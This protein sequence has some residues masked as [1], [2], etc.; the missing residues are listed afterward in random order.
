MNDAPD[1]HYAKTA[2]GVR[3]AYQ[4]IGEPGTDVIWLSGAQYPI[5]LLWDWPD[6]SRFFMR[7]ASF[8]RVLLLDP[9]GWG[10][11]EV[12]PPTFE[13]FVDDAITVMDA[14]GSQRATLVGFAEGGPVAIL[15]AAIFPE[16]TAGLILLNTFAKWLRS[17][18]YPCGLP[19]RAADIMLAGVEA[20]WG[21]GV[22]AVA[23][24]TMAGDDAFR[25]WIAR[26]ERLGAPPNVAQREIREWMSRDL[27]PILT[28]VRVPTLVLHRAD[29][30]FIRVGNGRY[31]AEHLPVARYVELAGADHL[32]CAGD[33]DP[34]LDEIEEFVTGAPPVREPDRALATVL[35]TD[36]V[37]PPNGR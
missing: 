31:L 24:P 36:I 8:S 3:I 26:G 19:Q 11:S 35:F 5:D 30:A 28:T 7:I 2:D 14:V 1:T 16:R 33:Q 27:R 32:F 23:S 4:V 21:Q 6:A 13:S 29:S 34:I 37:A 17:D 18:D 15:F 22:N 10:A 12:A 9:H 25:R 20:G